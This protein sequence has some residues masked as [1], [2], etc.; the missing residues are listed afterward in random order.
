MGVRSFK[1]PPL[2]LDAK[3]SVDSIQWDEQ[4]VSEP[5]LIS[6][7]TDEQV[8][9]FISTGKKLNYPSILNIPCHTQAVERIVQL[10]VESAVTNRGYDARNRYIRVRLHSRNLMPK[11][12]DK[13]HYKTVAKKD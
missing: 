2:N 12:G 11:F 13:K 3:D 6:T 7:F 4:H 5:P 10:V 8:E 9:E 1:V